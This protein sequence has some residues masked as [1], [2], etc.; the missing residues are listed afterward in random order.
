MNERNF[1]H[2]KP[3]HMDSAMEVV[4]DLYKVPRTGWVRRGVS[5]EKMESVGQHTDSMISLFNEVIDK[6]DPENKLDRRKILRMI[7]IH[8]WAESKVGDQIVHHDDRTVEQRLTKQKAKDDVQGME[9][10]CAKL[11]RE[12]EIVFALWNECEDKKTPE[13]QL[14]KQIDKLQTIE[15]A[16]EYEQVHE[17]SV[18]AW[19]FIK[20]VKE[21]N[22]ITNEILLKRMLEIEN[23]CKK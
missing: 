19:E 14:V 20:G 9:E 5:E 10:I 4:K 8:D 2:I 13:A 17:G 21:R 15:K 22:Q 12:G 23:K 3:H 1:D 11:G 6:I 16:W 7:Q 18:L